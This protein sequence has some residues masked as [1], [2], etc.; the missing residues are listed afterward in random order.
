MYSWF[1]L[2]YSRKWCGSVKQLPKKKNCSDQRARD[3][4]PN[5]DLYHNV[6][7]VAIRRQ[8]SLR[9]ILEAIYKQTILIVSRAGLG[10]SSKGG[11]SL[12][13]LLYFKNFDP[14]WADYVFNRV[15]EKNSPIS[16]PWFRLLALKFSMFQNHLKGLLK[17]IVGPHHHIFFF[18]AKISSIYYRIRFLVNEQISMTLWLGYILKELITKWNRLV[19]YLTQYINH[20]ISISIRTWFVKIRESI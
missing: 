14:H 8:G 6:R 1:S 18:L 9:V 15:K 20:W 7:G 13:M 16:S 11:F 4:N 19:W 3:E 17:Q 10:R 5:L 12:C 2:L